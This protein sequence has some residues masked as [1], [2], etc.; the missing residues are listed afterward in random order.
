VGLATSE[1]LDKRKP[2]DRSVLRRLADGPMTT[3]AGRIATHYRAT[4]TPDNR[5]Q[6]RAGGHLRHPSVGDADAGAVMFTIASTSRPR[7]PAPGSASRKRTLGQGANFLV[8]RGLED[9]QRNPRPWIKRRTA[10]APKP[11]VPSPHQPRAV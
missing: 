8:I 7:A 4:G 3:S 9:S 2:R 1:I 10:L 5:G 6:G 11:P